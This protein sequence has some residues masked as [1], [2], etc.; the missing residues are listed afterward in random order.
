MNANTLTV[1]EVCVNTRKRCAKR[2][3][4]IRGKLLK[5]FDLYTEI[6]GIFFNLMD[7]CN[8]IDWM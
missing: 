2:L 8:V 3:D 4:G 6:Y 1:R 5:T 7:Y